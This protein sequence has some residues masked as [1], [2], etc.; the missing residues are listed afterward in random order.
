MAGRRPYGLRYCDNERV[1]EQLAF[2]E[3]LKHTDIRLLNAG[4]RIVNGDL[5]KFCE[6]Q[7]DLLQWGESNKNYIMTHGVSGVDWRFYKHPPPEHVYD[8]Y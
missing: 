4:A 7:A 2:Q 5:R 8:V 1:F 6:Q 3:W